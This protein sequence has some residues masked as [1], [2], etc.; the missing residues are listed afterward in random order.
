MV[1]AAQLQRIAR[2]LAERRVNSSLNIRPTPWSHEHESVEKELANISNL[3]N[4]TV[5]EKKRKGS[6]TI[7]PSRLPPSLTRQVDEHITKRTGL[8]PDQATARTFLSKPGKVMA[9]SIVLDSHAY[10]KVG[11]LLLLNVGMPNEEE[12]KIANICKDAITL[13]QP[14]VQTHATGELVTQLPTT[15][16][17]QVDEQRQQEPIRQEERP[18]N[19]TTAVERRD[20]EEGEAIESWE[21]ATDRLVVVLCFAAGFASSLA[22]FVFFVKHISEDN[23]NTEGR[24]QGFKNDGGGDS[25]NQLITDRTLFL[26]GLR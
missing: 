21:E 22:I 26:L 18:S 6:K 15:W 20:G 24:R 17:Q 16:K 3:T 13:T 10:L 23:S 8:K 7:E 12:V 4:M 25:F 9:T 11:G 5:P 19:S 14:L 1:E 2:R